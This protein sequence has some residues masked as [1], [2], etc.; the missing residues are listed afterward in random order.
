VYS[1]RVLAVGQGGLEH[2]VVPRRDGSVEVELPH[3]TLLV[4]GAHL[5]GHEQTADSMISMCNLINGM[6]G[7]F[8]A[9]RNVYRSEE[10]EI[11]RLVQ[12][13]NVRKFG[14]TT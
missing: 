4:R 12:V 8:S 10:A 5:L 14:I 13:V 7:R 11:L 9:G 1:Y 3:V 6:H 2:S